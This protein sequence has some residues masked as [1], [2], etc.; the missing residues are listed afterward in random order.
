MRVLSAADAIMP[1]FERTKLVLFTPFRVGRTWKLSATGYV[2]TGGTFFFPF[3]VLALYF[4]PLIRRSSPHWVPLAVVPAI[5]LLT[6]LIWFLFVIC[7]RLQFVFFDFVLNRS[8]FVSPEWRKYSIPARRFTRIKIAIGSTA[9]ILLG[10]L[11]AWS[12]LSQI[13]ADKAGHPYL[14]GPLHSP[15]GFIALLFFVYGGLGLAMLIGSVI[16]DF[17]LPSVALENTSVSDAVSRVWQLTAQEPGQ[18]ALYALFKVILGF[19]VQMATSIAAEIVFFI[20]AGIIGAAS[21]AVGWLLHAIGVPQIVLQGAGMFIMI[22]VYLFF[23]VYCMPM[24]AGISSTF[25]ES[26]KLCFLGGR[27]PILGELMDRSTAPAPAEFWIQS[28]I[29]PPPPLL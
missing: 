22:A 4:L 7:S 13:A 19:T 20:F 21:V 14:P 27:Y 24:I 29:T 16:N 17:A 18:V 11:A 9:T 6:A 8:Q 2:S 25:L 15:F 28:A 3:T 26:Y 5:V 1:A 12:V 10:S 23:V